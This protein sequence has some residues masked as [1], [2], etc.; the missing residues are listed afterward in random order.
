M[1]LEN[2]I[3]FMNKV[4][5]FSAFVKHN[6]SFKKA[7]TPADEKEWFVKFKNGEDTARELLIEHNLRL[8]SHIV[9]K[10]STA[11]EADDFISVGTIGLIKAINTFNP[12]KGNQLS[13]YASRCIE[14]EIL[15]LIR[16][17]KKHRDVAS[18]DER[19]GFDKD[20]NDILISEVLENKEQDIIEQTE[21]NIL[22]Q[23]TCL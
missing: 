16:A 1:I 13:T 21:N 12:D 19:L 14:N 11:G 6:S 2:F 17:T 23:N 22:M 4:M 18:L 9:K 5:C 8:V 7:L 10:Y 15:M 3:A 20:G